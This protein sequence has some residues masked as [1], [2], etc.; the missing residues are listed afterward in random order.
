MNHNA[1]V[2]IDH[3][4]AVIVSV[5]AGRATTTIVESEVGAHPRYSGQPGAGGEKKYEARHGQHLDEYYDEVIRHLAEPE[6]LLII[7]PGEAK[8]ELR[9]RLERSKSRA[10]PTIDVETADK[11]TDPQIVAR[12]KDH[13]GIE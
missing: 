10:K 7:G 1:G 6:E 5:S 9:K 2:W 3:K 11:L 4:R 8:L 13:F 12:V